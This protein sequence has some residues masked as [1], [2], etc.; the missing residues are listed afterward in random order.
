MSSTYWSDAPSH[1]RI[2]SCVQVLQNLFLH[3]RFR[4]ICQSINRRP[5]TQWHLTQWRKL[6]LLLPYWS[7]NWCSSIYSPLNPDLVFQVCLKNLV[8]STNVIFISESCKQSSLTLILIFWHACCI[9]QKMAK[10]CRWARYVFQL[11]LG[12]YIAHAPVRVWGNG[13]SANKSSMKH[14]LLAESSACV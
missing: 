10:S 14:Y 8:K 5:L 1:R 11:S 4:D 7:I 13:D 9:R 12:V 3:I 2:I 6:R